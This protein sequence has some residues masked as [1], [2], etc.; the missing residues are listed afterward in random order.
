[1]LGFPASRRIG[2]GGINVCALEL[3]I[4]ALNTSLGDLKAGRK[5]QEEFRNFLLPALASAELTSGTR[6]M[7]PVR[8]QRTSGIKPKAAGSQGMSA[9][10]ALRWSSGS[11]QLI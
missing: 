1:M 10:Q 9:G 7:D 8:L 4:A 3:E 6:S 5:L 2:T 11:A